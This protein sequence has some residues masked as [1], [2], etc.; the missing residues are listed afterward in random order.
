[1]PL[2]AEIKQNLL[3]KSN[4]I[5]YVKRKN[6]LKDFKKDFVRFLVEDDKKEI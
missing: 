2:R 4:K 3:K 6:I 1:M 5:L